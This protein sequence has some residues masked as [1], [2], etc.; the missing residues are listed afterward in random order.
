MLGV[1]YTPQSHYRKTAIHF[2]L[3]LRMYLRQRTWE[4]HIAEKA[5]GAVLRGR[6]ERARRAGAR[7]SS[8]CI[9]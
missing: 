2:I 7:A 8:C 1:P 5:C 6:V 9:R 3:L 4:K